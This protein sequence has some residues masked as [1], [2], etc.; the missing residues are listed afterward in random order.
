MLLH[1]CATR[2]NSRVG[3]V[4]NRTTTRSLSRPVSKTMIDSERLKKW[5]KKEEK[6]ASLGAAPTQWPLIR[7]A[8]FRAR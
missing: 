8:T 7:S 1:F 6:I 5:S 4:E 3:S 2:L